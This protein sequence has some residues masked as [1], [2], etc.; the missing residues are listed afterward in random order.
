[1]ETHTQTHKITSLFR[2]KLFF[3]SYTMHSMYGFLY[4]SYDSI[5]DI[6]I[7][8]FKQIEYHNS[9]VNRFR[10]FEAPPPLRHFCD[11]CRTAWTFQQILPDTFVPVFSPMSAFPKEQKGL[12]RTQE[13]YPKLYQETWLCWTHLDDLKGNIWT[14][15]EYIR[16]YW[17]IFDHFGK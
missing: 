10:Q 11:A 3:N 8:L 5:H 4:I 6:I 9:L 16:S 13:E 17:T 7:K 12:H 14:I 15:Q 1:M 2:N